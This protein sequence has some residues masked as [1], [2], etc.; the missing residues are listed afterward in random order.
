MSEMIFDFLV[1]GKTIE[2]KKHPSF[3]GVL[4]TEVQ[5]DNVNSLKTLLVKV[6]SGKAMLPHIHENEIEIHFVISGSG[7]AIIDS[8]KVEYSKGRISKIPKGI[9]HE[10]IAGSDGLTMIALFIKE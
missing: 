1:K 3:D 8:H 5:Y 4:L 10:V 9:Q 2:W 7:T 6:D